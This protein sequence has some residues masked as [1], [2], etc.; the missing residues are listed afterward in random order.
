M[1]HWTWLTDVLKQSPKRFVA[2]LC[3]SL[4]SKQKKYRTYKIIN[5]LFAAVWKLQKWNKKK[6]EFLFHTTN[7]REIDRMMWLILLR[8]K[9]RLSRTFWS[10]GNW[11]AVLCFRLS[12][13]YWMSSKL[14]FSVA[15]SG[16][17]FLVLL[18]ECAEWKLD[19]RQSMKFAYFILFYYLAVHY[20]NVACTKNWSTINVKCR[21]GKS[22]SANSAKVNDKANSDTWVYMNT[23]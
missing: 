3:P 11:D 5:S 10:L 15:K 4:T 12:F 13:Q 8:W 17:S 23:F 22:M 9:A 14:G 19:S 16:H 6:K 7:H 1:S 2:Y 18:Y 21:V 20:K